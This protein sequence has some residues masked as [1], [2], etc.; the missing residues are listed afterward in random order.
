M[1]SNLKLEKYQHDIKAINFNDINEYYCQK[2]VVFYDNKNNLSA[3]IVKP[4][5][6]N[7]IIKKYGQNIKIYVIEQNKLF[8][9]LDKNF[10]NLKTHKA[11]NHLS[12]TFNAPNAKTINYKKMVIGF[13]IL[14]LS[15]L[16]LVKNI[17]NLINNGIYLIQ[18]FLKLMLFKASIDEELNHNNTTIVCRKLP[19]YTILVPLYKES[20]KLNS[21][22][23]AIKKL[24]YPKSK[25]DVK[26]ILE[27]DDQITIDELKKI[28]LPRYIH[29]IKVPF[30]LP[31]TK[32]KA[33][34]YAMNSVRGK[35]LGVYDA[36]DRPDPDQLLKAINAFNTLPKEYVCVQAR[37]NF[38]NANENI[39][40]KFFSIEYSLW[41]KYLL[42]GLN[43]YNL[44]ITL[45]GTSNHFKVSALK[46]VGYWDA[47]NVTEDADLGIRLYL[48]DFKV[49]LIDS[50]TLEEAPIFLTSWCWQRSRWIKGFFQTFYVFLIRTKD[51]K[52][53][54]LLN[55]F[56]VY[57]FIGFASYS[58][59]CMPWLVIMFL[60]KLNK[61]IYYLWIINAIVSLTYMYGAI[62]YIIKEQNKLVIST[63][64]VFI[65]PLYFILHTIA[66]YISI[67]E[68]FRSPF[69]WQKTQHGVS[70]QQDLN[71]TTRTDHKTNKL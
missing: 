28:N 4:N 12:E 35:Y 27:A 22:I 57:V 11:I 23:S 68:M 61:Y 17:F 40:T 31:R 6:F 38:Y 2:Y 33:M 48:N 58:F 52:N 67:F 20:K 26:F 30:S 21:I 24:H 43:K 71:M 15:G 29:L 47:Y 50:E 63:F 65:W 45:G 14:F 39:L 7:Y 49:H 55:V 42:K 46:K 62:Y 59:V 64:T 54:G 1:V 9:I 66:A 25:L 37:L 5:L 32:P 16:L 8:A 56:S 60:F 51:Y 19:I 34:N 3:A 69:K 70:L 13:I 41:F 44:P 53:F 18:N 10:E 36:E